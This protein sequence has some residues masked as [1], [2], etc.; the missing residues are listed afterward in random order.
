MEHI[1]IKINYTKEVA[2]KKTLEWF[3]ARQGKHNDRYREYRDIYRPHI[4]CVNYQPNQ[5]YYTEFD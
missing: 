5:S 2:I 4:L 1:N 3:M